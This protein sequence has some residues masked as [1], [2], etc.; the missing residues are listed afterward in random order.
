MGRFAHF[1]KLVH[2]LAPPPPQPPLSDIS[3]LWLLDTRIYL[4]PATQI[5]SFKARIPGSLY[6][7]STLQPHVNNGYIT[8]VSKLWSRFHWA[9]AAGSAADTGSAAGTVTGSAAV[10]AAASAA[11]TAAGLAGG[12]IWLRLHVECAAVVSA[13]LHGAFRPGSWL[14]PYAVCRPT[15]PASSPESAGMCPTTRIPALLYPNFRLY[16]F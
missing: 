3:R 6:L 15:G 1:E 11:T 12:R 7:H 13:R 5:C 9:A 8:E 4:L 10:A 16:F 14:P 2:F